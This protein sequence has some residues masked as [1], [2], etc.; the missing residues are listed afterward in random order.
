[1]KTDD[2]IYCAY[3]DDA[4]IAEPYRVVFRH[5]VRDTFAFQLFQLRVRWCEFCTTCIEEIKSI[6]RK[7]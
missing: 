6:W 4:N 7:R 2:E 5:K 3:C 1:M